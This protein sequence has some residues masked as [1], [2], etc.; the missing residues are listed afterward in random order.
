[1]WDETDRNLRAAR[2]RGELDVTVAP[3][4]DVETRLGAAKTELQ[5]EHDAQ[6][7]KNKCA[8]RYYGI[9]SLRAE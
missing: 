3:V 2:G 6:N 7:W 8:A 9:N 5:I 1:T 4:D